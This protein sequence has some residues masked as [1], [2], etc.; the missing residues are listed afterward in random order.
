MAR[1]MN[2]T[3]ALLVTS[4]LALAGTGVMADNGTPFPGQNVPEKLIPFPGL[5]I[6]G[7]DLLPDQIHECGNTVRGQ[8]A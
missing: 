7:F 4:I 6:G 1:H 3:A 5:D 8:G 2:K